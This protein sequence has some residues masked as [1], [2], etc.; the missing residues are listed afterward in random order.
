MI[1]FLTGANQGKSASA[2]GTRCVKLLNTDPGIGHGILTAL[3]QQPN[4]TIIACVRE[5]ASASAAS[6]QT[7]RRASTTQLI[8]MK[9]DPFSTCDPADV[10]ST[11]KNVHNITRI[12]VVL[13]AAGKEQ[14]LAQHSAAMRKLTDHFAVNTLAPLLLFQAVSPLL[15]NAK[16]RKG[17]FVVITSHGI[18]AGNREQDPF[19][20]SA[21]GSSKA[22]ANYIVRKIHFENDWLTTFIIHPG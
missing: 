3:L 6:L 19:E 9:L 8:F 16:D 12:D 10:V 13:A 14:H 21:Y 5:P 11:L 1:Y 18:G 22:A 17:K 7:L 20:F 2:L 15:R 4:N